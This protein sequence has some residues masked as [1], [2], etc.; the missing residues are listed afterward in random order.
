MGPGKQ[1]C[2]YFCV[3]SENFSWVSE[4]QSEVKTEHVSIVE[5]KKRGE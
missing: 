2:K 5:N 1:T 3:V 4:K